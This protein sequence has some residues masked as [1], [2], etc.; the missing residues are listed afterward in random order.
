MLRRG[1]ATP[2]SRFL[3]RYAE[4][5]RLHRAAAGAPGP[6]GAPGAAK[7]RSQHRQGLERLLAGVLAD[8]GFATAEAAAAGDAAGHWGLGAATG[9]LPSD[10]G[11]PFLAYLAG[12]VLA[13]LG[14][15]ALA[16]GAL[17]ECGSG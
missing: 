7:P 5:L 13:D 15:E 9:G 16:R 17:S 2:V 4:Y 1:R 6:R 10:H 3:Q 12:M 11:D 8:L 14:H